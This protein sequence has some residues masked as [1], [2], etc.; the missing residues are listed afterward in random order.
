M[1][2]RGFFVIALN[3]ALGLGTLA[4]LSFPTAWVL[5]MSPE[6]HARDSDSDSF[7]R[8]PRCECPEPPVVLQCLEVSG[9]TI[10]C[11]TARDPQWREKGVEKCWV[12]RVWMQNGKVKR[13]K[14]FAGADYEAVRRLA[15]CGAVEAMGARYVRECGE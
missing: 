5:M 13:K 1:I 8:P 2:F 10:E 9:C 14:L 6:A 15:E 3:L 4:T 12:H 11:K 7:H